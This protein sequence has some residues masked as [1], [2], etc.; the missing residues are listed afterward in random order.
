LS[1]LHKFLFDGMPVRG[2]IVRLTEAWQEILARRASN[3]STGAYPAPVAELLGEM[4]AAATLMQANI[5]FNGA[6]ILQ[7]FGDGPVKVAVAEVKPDL[8][9][10]A[11]A[12]VVGEL[13]ADAHLPEMVNVNNKGRC[14][15]TLDPKDKLPGQQPYQGVVPLHGDGGEKLDR[16]SEVLQHY[17]LQSE[18][19]DTTLVLAADDKVAAG[20][21]IQRLPVKGEANLEGTSA[22]DRDQANEDQIGRNEDYNRIS[23]LAS[24]LTRDELLTLDVETILRRLFWEEKLL[25]FEPQAGMLGPHFA[26]T[27]GRKRVAQMIRGLGAEE[28]EGILVERGDIEVGCDFCG[29][30]YRFDAVD[31]AQLF[32]APGDQLPASP[33]MQ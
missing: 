17:M 10:R 20:L 31:V 16:L 33:V 24:T 1:E 9:L 11:T 28:A 3:T 14:A 18:Q 26:C 12:K 19:L 23:I 6:L 5:K 8:S 7:I 22:S 4:T 32:T 2:M 27:C 29:K 30:Q 25:R 15:I 21:L 13:P